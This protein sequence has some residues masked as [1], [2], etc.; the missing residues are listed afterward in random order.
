MTRYNLALIP[1]TNPDQFILYAQSLSNTAP[2]DQYLIG[3]GQSIPHVSLCH[4]DADPEDIDTI[5]QQVQ[6]LTLPALHLTFDHH[7]SKAFAGNPK[8]TDIIWVSLMPDHRAQLKDLHLLIAEIIKEPLNASFDRYDP[9][10][11][12][13]N[14]RAKVACAELN[15]HPHIVP[16]FTDEFVIALGTTDEV[17]QVTEILNRV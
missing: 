7:L 5:W 13:F 6:T 16:A 9:H 2:A 4:F 11:T 8:Y 15:E 3:R 12:L 10:M 17:G 14:S 1:I